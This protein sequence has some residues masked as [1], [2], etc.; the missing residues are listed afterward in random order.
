MEKNS[1]GTLRYPG[2]TY[3]FVDAVMRHVVEEEDCGTMIDDLRFESGNYFHT[4][5]EAEDRLKRV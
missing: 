2:A 3:F 4:R 5:G 1:N